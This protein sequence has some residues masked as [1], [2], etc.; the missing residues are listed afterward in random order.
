MS[1]RSPLSVPRRSE[2]PFAERLKSLGGRIIAAAARTLQGVFNDNG[3]L[4]PI[5]VRVAGRRQRLD[6]S[7]PQ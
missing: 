4:I 5:P 1:S 7:Q 6:R 3:R 2:R